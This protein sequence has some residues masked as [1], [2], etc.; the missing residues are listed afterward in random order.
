MAMIIMMMDSDK[1][2][3]VSPP[4]LGKLG[5][6]MRVWGGRKMDSVY[7]MDRCDQKDKFFASVTVLTPTKKKISYVHQ[8]DPVK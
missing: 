1:V 3:A 4:L 7:E 6:C 8:H 2:T 5:I